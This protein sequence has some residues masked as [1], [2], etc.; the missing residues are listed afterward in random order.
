MGLN[1]ILL[2]SILIPT[3]K[4][5]DTG[6]NK[7]MSEQKRLN[8]ALTQKYDM[9]QLKALQKLEE[10]FM[11]GATPSPVACVLRDTLTDPRGVFLSES[12]IVPSYYPP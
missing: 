3:G 8:R 10:E 1:L 5:S 4:G 7:S 9:H 12:H 2:I 11:E 6:N